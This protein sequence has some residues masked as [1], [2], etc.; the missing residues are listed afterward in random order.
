MGIKQ[1]E[2]ATVVS[3]KGEEQ[4]QACAAMRTLV[5]HLLVRGFGTFDSSGYRAARL[6]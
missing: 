2:T 1:A 6:G 3:L 4:Q 5:L